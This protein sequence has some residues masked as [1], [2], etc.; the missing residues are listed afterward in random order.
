MQ[1]AA[2]TVFFAA[3]LINFSCSMIPRKLAQTDSQNTD[4]VLSSMRKSFRK[5]GVSLVFSGG[6]GKTYFRRDMPPLGYG[7][8]TDI[9][10]QNICF[11]KIFRFKER[12]VPEF[13]WNIFP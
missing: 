6:G 9:R 4:L 12:T 7:P 1:Q 5:V 13:L 2:A 3:G 8:G 11:K 10:F